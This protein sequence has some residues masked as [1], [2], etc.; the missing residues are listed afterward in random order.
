MYQPS[1]G[2]ETVTM[3]NRL[4]DTIRRFLTH[5]DTKKVAGEAKEAAKN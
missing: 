3:A 5:E 2:I 1:I 4:A